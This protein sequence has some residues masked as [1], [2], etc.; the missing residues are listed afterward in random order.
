VVG[1]TSSRRMRKQP[2][3]VREPADVQEPKP[4]LSSVAFHLVSPKGALVT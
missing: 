4:P 1:C 2:A 3:D